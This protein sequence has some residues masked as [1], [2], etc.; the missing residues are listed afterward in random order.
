MKVLL[1]NPPASKRYIRDYYCGEQ[2]KGRYVFPPTD[3][4]VLS[5]R[6]RD[7]H[8][9]QVLDAIAE[10]LGIP[11]VLDRVRSLRPDAIV[12]LASSA[13]WVE[14]A[15]CFD[16]IRRV[17]D[18]PILLTG[19]LPRAAPEWVLSRHEA[20]FGAILDFT[21]CDLDP[22]LR[23]E[24]GALVSLWTRD[25]R[26]ATAPRSRRVSYGV[27]RHDLFP[28]RRY[29]HPLLSR[30]PY[31]VLLSDFGCPHRCT[32]CAYERLP[33]KTRDLAEV[34]EELRFIAR[35]G[36][37]ALVINDA[38][39]GAIRPRAIELCG[40]LASAPTRFRWLCDMRADDADPELLERM[41]QAGCE[42]V[43]FGVET[44][45]AAVL[46]SVRKSLEPDQVRR[47]FSTARR[48]GLRTLAHFILGLDGETFDSQLRLIEF[49]LELDPDYASFGIAVPTWGTT[50]RDDLVARGVIGP[51]EVG[52]DV[53]AERPLWT[54]KF[55]SPSDVERLRRL[56]IRRFYFRASYLWRRLAAVRSA[57][58]ARNLVVQ[59]LHLAGIL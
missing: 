41:K 46:S 25:S 49:A 39:F 59:A 22:F 40:L 12:S 9:I 7:G 53:S 14:D 13:S 29:H 56:A 54:S 3:L 16:A 36:V 8:E 28:I 35:L 51:D 6:L 20:V 5:A 37:H 47:A 15:A 50:F 27:P 55:L 2:S 23:G 17:H 58:E 34:A 42:C 26:P 21:D 18:A 43:M 45:T 32:F 44:P 1:L 30:H 24:R 11:A 38:S 31:T 4:L 10:G 48:I 19:D 33:H 57:Y 52:F